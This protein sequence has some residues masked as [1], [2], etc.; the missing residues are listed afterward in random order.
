MTQDQIALVVALHARRILQARDF[1]A[2]SDRRLDHD[3]DRAQQAGDDAAMCRAEAAALEA[4]L[5]AAGADVL[6][7]DAG[8]LSLFGDGQ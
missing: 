7:P 2:S 1:E 3:P 4:L 6:I 8:Q 5:K